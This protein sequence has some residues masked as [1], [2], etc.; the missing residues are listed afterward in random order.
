MIAESKL[1]G[2]CH[3]YRRLPRIYFACALL[4]ELGPHRCF[5]LF[6]H[7][8]PVFPLWLLSMVASLDVVPWMCTVKEDRSQYVQLAPMMPVMFPG[9]SLEHDSYSSPAGREVIEDHRVQMCEE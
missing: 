5:L 8:L 4:T 6:N 1:T 3:W 2:E 9:N 7:G